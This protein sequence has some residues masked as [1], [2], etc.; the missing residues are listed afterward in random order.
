MPLFGKKKTEKRTEF[1]R[2]EGQ[3]PEIPADA[4]LE[5]IKRELEFPEP[6]LP[7]MPEMPS[8]RLTPPGE[9]IGEEV[10][11]PSTMPRP[12]QTRQPMAEKT[13]MPSRSF[14]REIKPKMR[15]PIFVKIDKFKEAVESLETINKK[16]QELNDLMMKIKETRAREEEEI[17]K[18]EMEIQEIKSRLTIIDQKLFSKLE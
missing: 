10:T 3:I 12:P 16:I 9:F 6:E 7:E 2:E 18:W 1:R 11:R 5:S 15:E 14:V 17:T 4:E 8:S 13:E